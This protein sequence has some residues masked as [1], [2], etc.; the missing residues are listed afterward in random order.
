MVRRGPI[1][2]PSHSCKRCNEGDRWHGSVVSVQ[3][4]H[5]LRRTGLLI[6]R[7][8]WVRAPPAPPAISLEFPVHSW[9]G[10]WTDVGGHAY[11]KCRDCARDSGASPCK[12]SGNHA[13]FD[14]APPSP[15][16][17][18]APPA[19]PPPS[20]F[21]PTPPAARNRPS[22]S[23]EPPSRPPRGSSQKPPPASARKRRPAAAST[24]SGPVTSD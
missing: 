6:I 11:R 22:T 7:R 1:R 19:P 13:G 16:P 23:S 24:S 3:V 17:S 2:G 9:T 12:R 21:S 15:K 8:S 20:P 10:S 18:S 4:V 5:Q 14:A